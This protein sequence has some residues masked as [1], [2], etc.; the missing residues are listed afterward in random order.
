MAPPAEG[1]AGG[2]FP[3][4]VT[5]A[6]PPLRWRDRETYKTLFVHPWTYTAGAVILALLNIALL[7]ATGKAWG[8]TTSLAYWGSWAWEALGGDPHRWAYFAEVK[9][10]FNAPGFNLLK[11][12]GSLTNLGI[13]AG[14]L[15]SVLLAGQFRVKR[16][17]SRRQI[18]A[19]VLGGLVMGLGARIAFGCNIGDLFT[20]VPSMSLHGWVFMVSIFLGAMAGSKLLI[21]YFI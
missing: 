21:K 11:D 18:A 17:K 10:A 14:A 19:A 9:P 8:V 20:A 4:A 13:V 7:A 3:H 12:A 2:A 5:A 15:L 1:Q 6:A 16:L